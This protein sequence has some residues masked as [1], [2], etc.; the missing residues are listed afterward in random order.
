M[1]VVSRIC[2]FAF[3]GFLG[4]SNLHL[5]HLIGIPHDKLQM[6]PFGTLPF[7]HK[8][9]LRHILGPILVI[10]KICHFF[11]ILGPFE[12]FSEN[13]GSQKISFLNEGVI[14]IPLIDLVLGGKVPRL[15]H[16]P[17]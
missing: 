13:G 4:G 5:N 3:S 16:G 17:I 9:T 6:A 11:R 1:Y 10:F 12:Y 7:G 15:N 14:I 8:E 2:F